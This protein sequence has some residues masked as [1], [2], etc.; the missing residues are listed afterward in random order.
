MAEL[1]RGPILAPL[2]VKTPEADA[3]KIRHVWRI[4]IE[5]ANPSYVFDVALSYRETLGR[6]ST[7]RQ[8]KW[9]MLS[10]VKIS[11]ETT[12]T[13]CSCALISWVS[14]QIN[15]HSSQPQ[16]CSAA[17]SFFST[18]GQALHVLVLALPSADLLATVHGGCG[19]SSSQVPRFGHQSCHRGPLHGEY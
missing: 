8:L 9:Q 11:L 1:H 5:L 7:V 18:T 6:S 19:P 3:W 15:T 10:C 13:L 14:K 4:F 16:P 12:H 17:A 2:H